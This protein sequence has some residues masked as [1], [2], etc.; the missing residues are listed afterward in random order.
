[1]EFQGESAESRWIFTATADEAPIVGPER[2]AT[3]TKDVQV[4]KSILPRTGQ[5]SFKIFYILG[6]AVILLGMGLI[7]RNRNS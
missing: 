6:S 5:L 3:G 1:N 2:P 4:K 7:K